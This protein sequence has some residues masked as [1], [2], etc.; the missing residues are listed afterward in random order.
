VRLE[1]NIGRDLS[2]FE[3]H[4]EGC[5]LVPGVVQVGW[6]IELGRQYLVF[7]GRFRGMRA[8]KFMRVIVPETLITLQLD[9]NEA[10]RELDFAFDVGERA[11]S[12]GTML[13][14]A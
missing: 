11:V 1:L 8:V 10:T 4:F 5:P 12:S 6:A 2:Y 9:Y 7:Q 13:F 3:G 14:D